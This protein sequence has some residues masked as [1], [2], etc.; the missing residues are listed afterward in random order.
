MASVGSCFM[1]L[2]SCF[3]GVVVYAYYSYHGCG[4]MESGAVYSSN[5][6]HTTPSISINSVDIFS[7]C[8]TATT[9]QAMLST[10]GVA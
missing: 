7:L 1:V 3:A 2:L 10:L 5:Q 6:V 4:P 8:L 9:V